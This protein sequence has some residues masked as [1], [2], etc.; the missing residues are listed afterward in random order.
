[1]QQ[2]QNKL[3]PFILLGIILISF[4]FGVVLLAYLFLFGAILGIILY[5]LTWLRNTFFV[6]KPPIKSQKQRGRIIDTDD[7]NR[8]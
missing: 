4:F 1:M 7:W 6:K 3:A 8:L 5:T 2:F